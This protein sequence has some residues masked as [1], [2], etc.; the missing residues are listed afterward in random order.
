MIVLVGQLLSY[1]I[2]SCFFLC[3]FILCPTL[4]TEYPAVPALSWDVMVTTISHIE[5]CFQLSSNFEYTWQWS[6]TE[7]KQGDLGSLGELGRVQAKMTGRK[8][9]AKVSCRQMACRKWASCYQRKE[10]H[11]KHVSETIVPQL[12]CKRKVLQTIAH[13]EHG[14]DHQIQLARTIKKFRLGNIKEKQALLATYQSYTGDDVYTVH[15][16]TKWKASG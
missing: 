11:P 3:L 10:R 1:N 6:G 15:I 5:H 16:L 2:F 13:Q 14:K 9:W 4:K 7:L 8:F 12:H